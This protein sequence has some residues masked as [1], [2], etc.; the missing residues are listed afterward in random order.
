[1][2]FFIMHD[3]KKVPSFF[4]KHATLSLSQ[5]AHGLQKMPGDVCE[6]F[7]KVILLLREELL[8]PVKGILITLLILFFMDMILYINCKAPKTDVQ[9]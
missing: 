7:A 9:S 8:S 6:S 5:G 4:A 2:F 1:M 3:F